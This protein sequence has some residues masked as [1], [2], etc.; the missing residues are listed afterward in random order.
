MT[1]EGGTSLNILVWEAAQEVHDFEHAISWTPSGALAPDYN[2]VGANRLL[3]DN[4][5]RI[6]LNLP[7]TYLINASFAILGVNDSSSLPFSRSVKMFPPTDGTPDN[8]NVR[9][10]VPTTQWQMV[11]YNKGET[12]NGDTKQSSSLI[13][14]APEQLPCM[15]DIVVTTAAGS[16][17]TWSN[18]TVKGFDGTSW[19]SGA[20]RSYVEIKYLGA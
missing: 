3:Y 1:L 14:A 6:T 13:H 5:G 19:I 15:I 20:D 10:E 16:I 2:A 9:P 17:N 18:D 7:G 8:P 12:S 4:K 11:T